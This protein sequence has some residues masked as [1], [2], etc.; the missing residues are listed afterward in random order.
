MSKMKMIKVMDVY[1][2]V[3]RDRDTYIRDWILSRIE[4]VRINDPNHNLHTEDGMVDFV[5][6]QYAWASDQFDKLAEWKQVK[7]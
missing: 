4:H 2:P 1:K 7:K 6:A 5:I 3:W